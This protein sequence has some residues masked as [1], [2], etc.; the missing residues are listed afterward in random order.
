MHSI[1]VRQDRYERM[2]SQGHR[3]ALTPKKVLKESRSKELKKQVFDLLK[4]GKKMT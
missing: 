2:L 3:S 1:L 4:N